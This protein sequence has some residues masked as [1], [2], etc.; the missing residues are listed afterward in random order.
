M[1]WRGY[2]NGVIGLM[3][4]IAICLWALT[5]DDYFRQHNW[6]LGVTLGLTGILCLPLGRAVNRDVPRK[7]KHHLYFIPV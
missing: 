7:W 1:I 4:I 3:T 2:G 5:G 6:P